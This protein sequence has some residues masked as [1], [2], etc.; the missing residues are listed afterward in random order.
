LEKLK[1]FNCN[2]YSYLSDDVSNAMA[3]SMQICQQHG[4]YSEGIDLLIKSEIETARQKI[5]ATLSIQHDTLIFNAA[6]HRSDYML[7]QALV[8]LL[9]IRVVVVNKTDE[10][11]FEFLKKLES[12]GNIELIELKSDPSGR[13]DIEDLKKSISYL[14]H[15]T[16]VTLS[17]ADLRT[18]TMLPLK[19]LV[20]V[21][22]QYNIFLH[23]NCDLTIGK[24]NLDFSKLT[25]D[26]LSFGPYLVQGPDG[27]GAIYINPGL[28][29][30]SK[31]F[32]RLLDF[33]Q[34]HEPQNPVLIAGFEKAME[35]ALL[36]IDTY[37]E[38]VKKIKRYLIDKL[39]H[40]STI[41][42][43]L[44]PMPYSGLINTIPLMVN[45][46]EPDRFLREKLNLK[47]ISIDTIKQIEYPGENKLVPVLTLA[48][49]SHTNQNDVDYLIETLIEFISEPIHTQ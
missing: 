9:G 4:F 25:P 40:S 49:N 37:Q 30:E 29:S 38:K 36:A 31:A 5:A 10:A 3:L 15:K 21:C 23:L 20:G 28:K 45:M 42:N 26:F 16:L 17:H 34:A 47:G 43:V 2:T 39:A 46:V 33:F 8:L 6:H 32:N 22:K 24:Y 1:N 7:I 11:K 13:I 35:L 27:I 14:S 12:S 19:E 41:L 48:I 18:G 44:K